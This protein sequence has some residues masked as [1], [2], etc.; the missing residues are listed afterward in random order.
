MYEVARC[1]VFQR[2]LRWSLIAR[3]DRSGVSRL[4]GLQVNCVC[5]CFFAI[6]PYERLRAFESPFP[7]ICQAS[8]M[9]RLVYGTLFPR[10]M[11]SSSLLSLVILRASVRVTIVRVTLYCES[12]FFSTSFADLIFIFLFFN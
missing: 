4:P 7:Q 9:D 6:K 5:V 10:T 2:E 11:V 12:D 3:A 1:S 8:K